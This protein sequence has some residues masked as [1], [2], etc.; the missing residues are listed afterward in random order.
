LAASLAAATAANS[1][2]PNAKPGWHTL[3]DPDQGE[4][5][6]KL[7]EETCGSNSKPCIRFTHLA[8]SCFSDCEGEFDA[9]FCA[10][11]KTPRPKGFKAVKAWKADIAGTHDGWESC[12]THCLPVPSCA[13]MCGG[14]EVTAEE[15]PCET[16]CLD[17]YKAAVA[18]IT[19][20]TIKKYKAAD[21]DTC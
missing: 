8:H 5:S 7:S 11:E 13:S 20:T 9:Y 12:M 6:K 19:K 4:G 17:K 1:D 21:K 18:S 14:K 16:G 10:S 15:K 3:V 2:D